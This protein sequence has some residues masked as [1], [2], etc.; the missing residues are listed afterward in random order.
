[1]LESL[2]V[3]NFALI[4]EA[5]VEFDNNLNVLTGETGSGKSILIDS[6]NLC[7]GMRAS[8]DLMRNENE[9]TIVSIVF[10][11]DDDNVIEQI[12][13]LDIP[14]DETKKVIIYRKITKDKNISKINDE[15]CTLLKIKEVTELLIDI[16]GQHDSETLRKNNN[17][18]DFLDE[19]SGI[20][21]F[22]LK[23]KISNLYDE[24][25][26]FKDKLNEFNLDERIRL[27]EI[28]IL[29]YEIKEI[30]EAKLKEGE[31][32]ELAEKYKFINNYKNI[33]ESIS[34]TKNILQDVN[35]DLAIRE[36]KTALKFDKSVENIYNALIDASNIV[37]DNIKELDDLIS[38]FEYDEKSFDTIDKRLEVIRS[39][40]K[41]YN[42]SVSESFKALEEKRIRLNELMN[43]EDEK[44]KVID[45]I[46][47][48]YEILLTLCKQLSDLRQKSAIQFEN[49]LI[50]E[51]KDLGFLDVKFNIVISDKKDVSREGIDDVKFFISLNT[52]EKIK[53][54]SDIAS[55][56]ELSRIMLSIKTLLSNGMGT[57]TL[58]FDEVDAGISGITASKVAIKLN[59]ISKNH[60]VILITHLPQIAAMADHHFEIKKKV[61]NDRTE[62]FINKLDEK[63]MINEIGRLIGDGDMTP[64]VISSAKE[65]K[66][67]AKQ[68]KT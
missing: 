57:E 22:N 8:K 66:N 64:N 19:Y 67:K 29:E 10:K 61:I 39:V 68:Y 54:L 28:D 62:T 23:N 53:P 21:V 26:L 33:F 47:K 50:K 3:Q 16:Y 6:I 14:I 20:E 41:K 32:E 35:I 37:N 46:N 25:H 5:N 7:L 2:K 60:Q 30:E 43:Y 18:I 4:K 56:G 11:V 59:K 31:E 52:G 65:L 44:A 51:L 42:N 24:Y 34:A 27:R 36:L 13:Q 48:K 63:G 12:R 55:G 15:N 40:T 9:D 58:I 1:M 45:E 49:E 17:H 38:D